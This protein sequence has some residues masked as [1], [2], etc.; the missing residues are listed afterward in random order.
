[1]SLN[2]VQGWYDPSLPASVASQTWQNVRLNKRGEVRIIDFITEQISEGRGFQI[3]AGTIATGISAQNVIADTSADLCY[4]AATG[5][6]V[7]P[8]QFESAIRDVN[9]ALTLQ[10]YLKGVGVVSTSGTAFVPLSLLGAASGGYSAANTARVVADT[11]VVAAEAVTTTVRIWGFEDGLTQT[12]A[13]L[14]MG[15]QLAVM[16]A[17]TQLQYQQKGPGTMYVQVASTTAQTLHFTRLNVIE[18]NTAS[19]G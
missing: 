5:Y 14:F 2:Q 19:I 4:D 15:T 13:T 9:T 11:V 1:M 18:M 3:R 17:A 8:I 12:P 6:T 16:A 10:I 7:I